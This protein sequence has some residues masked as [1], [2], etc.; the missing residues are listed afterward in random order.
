M[1]SKQF[2]KIDAYHYKDDPV[3]DS[4]FEAHV[5]EEILPKWT[6]LVH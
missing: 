5:F 4:A 1:A 3:S 2:L 6:A